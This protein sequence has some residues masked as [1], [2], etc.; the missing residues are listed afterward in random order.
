MPVAHVHVDLGPGR[1]RFSLAVTTLASG[2]TLSIPVFVLQGATPGPRVGVSAMVH[3]DELDGLLIVR[4]LWRTLDPAALRGSVWLMPVANPLAMEAISRN[5]PID[6]LDMNRVFPGNPDGWLSELQAHAITTGFIDG[7]DC[8]VDIHAGGTFPWVDYCYIVNDAAFSRAFLSALLYEPASMYPNT[9]ASVAVARGIPITV[10]EIGGGYHDQPEHVRS[11]V[12]GVVN[13]LRHVGVLD[14][15]V[16][17]RPRQLL[18]R[19]IRVMRPHHG[20]VCVPRGTLTP[21]TWVDGGHEL[22]DIVSAHTFETLETMVA[23]FPKSVVV[24]ARNYATRVHPGDYGFMMG[25]GETATW[26]D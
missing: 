23:P 12:R 17:H 19:E 1:S 22:A 15:A 14:G 6:M 11:G 13:M 16:E 24:L 25:N 20:G 8:L 7:L 21:A 18:L 3:G 9:T 10:V 26:Y 5:T 2:Q 4:E